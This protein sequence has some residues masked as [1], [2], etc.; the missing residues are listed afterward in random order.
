MF[1]RGLVLDYDGPEMRRDVHLAMV[2]FWTSTPLFAGALAMSWARYDLGWPGVFLWSVM[3]VSSG[4]LTFREFIPMPKEGD[5]GEAR[6]APEWLAYP[7]V[8]GLTFPLFF[9]H[10]APF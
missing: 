2:A 7:L 3:V 10:N 4:F 5:R 9:M 8:F 1:A 6:R